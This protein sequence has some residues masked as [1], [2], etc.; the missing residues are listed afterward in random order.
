M[1]SF[2]TSDLFEIK[3]YLFISLISCMKT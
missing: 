3:F 1:P 2:L